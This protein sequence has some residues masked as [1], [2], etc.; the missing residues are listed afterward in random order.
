MHRKFGKQGL[1]AI[2]VSVDDVNDKEAV[3]EVK[4]FLRERKAT[5]ANYLLDEAP[6]VWQKKL[7]TEAIPCIFVFNRSGKVEQ[8]YLEARHDL[9]EKLVERLL[10]QK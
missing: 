3:D 5:M 9:V 6:E 10:Q 2:S 1:V 7:N 4:K 8:K